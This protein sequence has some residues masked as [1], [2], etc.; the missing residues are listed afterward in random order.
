[1]LYAT[2]PA[3]FLFVKPENFLNFL[4]LKD[5]EYLSDFEAKSFRRLLL[6]TL[7]HLPRP[8]DEAC[9]ESLLPNEDLPGD[10]PRQ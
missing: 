3:K 2:T 5:F 10:R 6:L 9:R 4:G 8:L 7:L 1:M